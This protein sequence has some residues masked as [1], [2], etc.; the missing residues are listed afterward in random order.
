MKDFFYLGII[1]II[2][3][4]GEKMSTLKPVGTLGRIAR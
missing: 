1:N 4:P 3:M 2:V